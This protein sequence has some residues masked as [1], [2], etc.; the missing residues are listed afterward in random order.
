MKRNN[1]PLEIIEENR[2]KISLALSLVTLLLLCVIITQVDKAFVSADR[3]AAS[4]SGQEDQNQEGDV[5]TV[6]SSVRILAAGNNIFDENILSAGQADEAAWNYDQVYSLIKDQIS[7]AD[8]SIVSQESAFTSE[9]SLVSGGPVYSTPVEVASALVNAGFDIIAGATEHADDFGSEHLA[10]SLAFWQSTYPDTAL[11]GLHSSQEE[12]A[13]IRVVE[14]NGI[15]IALLN[16][17]FGSSSDSIKMDAPFMVDYLEREKVASAIAQ[18]KSV[19]DCI[20]FLAHWGTVDSAVPTEYQNQWAQFLL[21]QG[22]KVVV[23][24]HPYVLQPCQILTD[25]A[26]NEMLVYYSLGNLVSGAQ[27]VP[28]L[29]GG[30]AGFTLE[31]TVTG[32]QTT[33]RIAD[34]SLTPVVMHYSAN[35]N[36]CNVYPLSA[37]TDDLARGH[38]INS[39]DAYAE[40]TMSVAA[41]QELFNYIMRLSVDVSQ[42]VNLL[43]YTFNPDTTLT[44]PDGSILYPGEIAAANAAEGSLDTLVQV[45]IDASA[46][47][48]SADEGQDMG[49]DQ[50]MDADAYMDSGMDTDTYTDTGMGGDLYMDTSMDMDP[51]TAMLQAE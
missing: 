51:Y 11:L 12:A 4:I 49:V 6:T 14:Q 42:N 41:F 24:S 35:L 16:Y 50:G 40:A 28:E 9:H 18:A 32:D 45:M 7:Q 25:G 21:Q 20:I 22:V 44:G 39:V 3:N 26:G 13:N 31:K 43:D 19:S 27:S 46:A 1:I 2:A 8:L 34:N 36:I 30:L 48:T 29:L 10:N 33:V 38:G 47:N 17:S 5:E 15:R 23:G 37:Y